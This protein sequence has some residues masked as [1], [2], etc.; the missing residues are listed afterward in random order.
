MCKGR[1]CSSV[2]IQ[3]PQGSPVGWI[4]VGILPKAGKQ[5]TLLGT[6]WMFLNLCL[7]GDQDT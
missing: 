7:G 1:H 2:A 5:H 3:R 6:P 4:P